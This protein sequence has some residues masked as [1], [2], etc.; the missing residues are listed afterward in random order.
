MKTP[1]TY[2]D[3]L[4]ESSSWRKT[5]RGLLGEAGSY[6]VRARPRDPDEA[7]VLR[8]LGLDRSEP[9][10]GIDGSAHPAIQIRRLRM[11][12]GLS[13]SDLADRLGVSQQQV[14]Q[15]EDPS[16]SNPTWSTLRK[17]ARALECSWELRLIQI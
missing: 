13:Q 15:L 16:R 2:D 1:I 8:R 12:A 6:G 5:A 14:Q 4:R 9:F 3:W 17:I 7:T 11:S 10:A